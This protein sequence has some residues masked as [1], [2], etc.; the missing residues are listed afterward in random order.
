MPYRLNVDIREF[1][2]AQ[3]VYVLCVEEFFQ[4]ADSVPCCNPVDIQ[5]RGAVCIVH[6]VV[7]GGNGGVTASGIVCYLVSHDVERLFGPRVVSLCG[8]D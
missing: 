3:Q 5:H 7:W 1:L 6:P 2:Y 4:H 8:W